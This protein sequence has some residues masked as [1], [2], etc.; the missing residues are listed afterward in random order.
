MS[1]LIV[2]PETPGVLPATGGAVLFSG[3]FSNWILAFIGV[4]FVFTVFSIWRLKVGEKTIEK[5]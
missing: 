2:R 5:K 3:F 4:V 1:Q